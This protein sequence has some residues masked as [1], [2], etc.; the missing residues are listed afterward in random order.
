VRNGLPSANKRD[1]HVRFKRLRLRVRHGL[2]Q[3][4]RSRDERVRGQY[5]NRRRKLWRVR[6]RLPSANKRDGHVRFKRLWFCVCHGLWQ[7][8]RKR[9]ERL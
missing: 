4:R 6:E 9:R 5:R 1:G 8:R 7:L 2:W 3:L